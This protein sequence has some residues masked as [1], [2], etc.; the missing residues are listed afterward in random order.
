MNLQAT[1]D[2]LDDLG[3]YVLE[4]AKQ[5]IE[6]CGPRPPGSEGETE[7][8]HLIRAELSCWTDGEAQI[9]PFSVAA[10]AFLS[11]PLVT[12]LLLTAALV[13]Y[14]LS[15]WFAVALSGM[16]VTVML[17]EFLFDKQF[18][19]VLF[20]KRTSYN[21]LGVQKPSGEV[22]QRLVLKAAT[23]RGARVGPALPV[24]EGLSHPVVLVADKPGGGVFAAR[25]CVSAADLVCRG[26]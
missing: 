21:V 18:M 4:K 8:Q 14:W 12:A 25:A 22:K 6:S 10:K 9:E 26:G 1:S 23:P 16:A 7:A 2:R 11:V 13:A 15:P 5:V 19:D 17:M 24:P 3:P 20:P